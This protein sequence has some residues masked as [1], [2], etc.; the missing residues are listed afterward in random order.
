MQE[1]DGKKKIGIVGPM[2]NRW[3]THPPAIEGVEFLL[4]DSSLPLKRNAEP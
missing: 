1:C 3:G 2:S 4:S